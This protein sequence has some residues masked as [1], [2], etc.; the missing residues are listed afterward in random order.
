MK[1]DLAEVPSFPLTEVPLSLCHIKGAMNKTDK[2]AIMK[3]LEKKGTE[4]SEPG[5]VD[6]CKLDAMFFLR[7]LPD[8]PPTFGGIA[9]LRL[10]KAS[11]YSKVVHIVCDTYSG[12]PSI[13]GHERHERG[14]YQT[15]FQITGPSQ[16][17]PPHFNQARLSSSFKTALLHFLRDEWT[18]ASYAKVLQDREIYFAPAA[19][20]TQPNM[21]LS[22]LRN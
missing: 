20:C 21:K 19:T 3:K 22:R 9:E 8:L 12:G 16:R 2:S 11:A 10:Q 17:R 7:T 5:Q 18:S 13:K 6:T 4:N 14:N 1:L 15:K